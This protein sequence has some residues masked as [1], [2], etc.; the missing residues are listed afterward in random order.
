MSSYIASPST[1]IKG[2]NE[3]ADRSA[4]LP[5]L[6]RVM[7]AINGALLNAIGKKEE[8]NNRSDTEPR[9]NDD[10][11]PW[12]A[13]RDEESNSI[14]C[15][16]N[17]D[18][19]HARSSGCDQLPRYSRREL[20]QLAPL[21]DRLGR[22]LTDAAPHIASFA[23]TLP[24]GDTRE[25]LCCTPDECNVVIA[26]ETDIDD[27]LTDN[28]DL[29]VDFVATGNSS[30][31]GTGMFSLSD[32]VTTNVVLPNSN[33]LLLNPMLNDLDDQL[34]DTILFND[35]DNSD[36]VA[37]MV[38]TAR[39]ENRT[40]RVSPGASNTHD[41]GSNLLSA[42]LAAA[43]LS[44]L[45]SDEGASNASEETIGLQGLGRLLRQRETGGSGGIDIHI[46]AFV[47]GPGV[48]PGTGFAMVADPRVG[49]IGG[50]TIPRGTGFA[51][52]SS[53]H[54]RHRRSH[55]DFHSPVIA[56]T[57]NEDEMGIFSELYSENP[58][59]VDLQSGV[60]PSDRRS[61]GLRAF[62]QENTEF[63]STLA[64]NSRLRSGFTP[65]G[66]RMPSRSPVRRHNTLTVVGEGSN[67]S[68]SS[69][70][71][72]MFRRALGRRSNPNIDRSNRSMD[73]S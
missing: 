47:T 12:I 25:P 35:P 60:L 38:N 39:G 22:A 13:E 24:K 28:E 19:E 30:S 49:G 16:D 71:S 26:G 17:D 3:P 27:E 11:L 33:T 18:M 53:L 56:S 5:E 32:G 42:Y 1:H 57:V 21:L 52:L 73:E 67:S 4:L 64:N 40:R 48:G 54:R 69:A 41:D 55:S 7:A 66:D 72:R 34:D 45:A 31:L 61:E 68:R 37:G 10:D 59:P 2:E 36:F 29:V 65:V 50:P 8:T 20:E 9:N 43:S 63:N 46:H 70:I 51:G 23:S 14:L 44:S 15:D 62:E 58:S 6:Q